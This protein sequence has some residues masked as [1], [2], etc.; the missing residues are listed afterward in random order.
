MST[1]REE[2]HQLAH[3]SQPEQEGRTEQPLRREDVLSAMQDFENQKQQEL[4]RSRQQEQEQINRQRQEA[5]QQV[6]N[7]SA[8]AV[9]EALQ[10]EMQKDKDFQKLVQSSDLPG[11][12]I[13]YIG[14]IGEP[15]EAGLIVRE[16]ANND[17]YKSQIQKSKTHASRKKI[18]KKIRKDVLTAGTHGKIPPILQK[19]IPAY[20]PNTSGS[21]QDSDYYAQVAIS[22]GI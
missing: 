5:E 14:D 20:N 3:E 9:K 13:D 22:N 21:G 10:E 19:E 1:A 7:E 6:L 17:E 4:Q 8:V 12:L 11:E 2:L 16:L 18:L 15:D